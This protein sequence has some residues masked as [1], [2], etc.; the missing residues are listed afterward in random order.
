MG[1][2]EFAEHLALKG[3]SDNTMKAYLRYYKL[4]DAGLEGKDL[5]Q[6]FINGFLLEHTSNVARA[7][8]KNLFEFLEITHLKIPKLTGRRSQK[9]RRSI[10]PQEIKVLRQW[11]YSNKNIRYLLLLDLSYYCALRRSEAMGIKI[12]DFDLKI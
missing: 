9:K 12:S 10:S 2:K 5:D 8:L 1:I 6:S 7:F 3:L 4:F 11:I